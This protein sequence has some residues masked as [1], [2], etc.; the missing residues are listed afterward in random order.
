M[1][2]RCGEN[3]CNGFRHSTLCILVLLDF[4]WLE[5][6]LEVGDVALE[7]G[8]C[9]VQENQGMIWEVGS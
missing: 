7:G 5:P 1:K 4:G 8:C 6:D 2:S 9:R 3:E